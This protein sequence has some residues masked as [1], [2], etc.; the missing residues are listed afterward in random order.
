MGNPQSIAGSPIAQFSPEPA[1]AEYATTIG[2]IEYFVVPA[3]TGVCIFEAEP[4]GG[5]GICGSVSRALAGALR[6]TDIAPDGA[7]TIVGLAPNT[8]T[9]VQL[10][11]PSGAAASAPVAGSI[12]V[13]T[14]REALPGSK[15]TLLNSSGARVTFTEVPNP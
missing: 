13:L 8:N 6:Y 5:G 12:F 7:T 10:T 1:E 11:E 2:D 15:A 14:G 3:A 4:G 9:Q